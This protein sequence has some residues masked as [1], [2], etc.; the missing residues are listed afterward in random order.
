MRVLVLGAGQDVGKSCVVVRIGGRTLMFDCGMHLGYQD[1][2]RF[3]DFGLLGPP[4]TDL[5]AVVDALLVSHFHLDHVGALPYFTEVLGY[6]GPIFMTYPTAAVAPLMLEDYARVLAERPGRGP[7]FGRQH[8]APALA[9]V[10]P[11]DLQETV[12]VCEGVEVTAYNAGHV[13]GAA[14]LRVT[15]GG[16]SLVYTGDFNTVP[17]RHLAGACLGR[18]APDLLISEATYATSVRDSKAAREA[19]LLSAVHSCVAGGGKVL[20][21]VFAV[22]RAQEL[23]LLLGEFWE[24]TQLDVPIYFSGPLAARASQYYRLLLNWASERVKAGPPGTRAAALAPGRVLPWSAELTHAPGPCVLFAT[25]GMLQGGTSLEVFKAWAPCANNLVLLPSYQARRRCARQRRRRSAA[26]AAAP[27][28]PVAPLT[29]PVVAGAAAAGQVAG[30]L[31]RKLMLGQR[32]G[33]VVDKAPL[34]V[35]CKVYYATVSAHADAKGILQLVAQVAPAAVL[36]VH[37]EPDKMA[38]MSA[39]IAGSLGLPCHTPA[40]GEEVCVSAHAGCV[41]VP[42]AAALLRRLPEGLQ[43]LRA[44]GAGAAAAG[45]LERG[46]A[47]AL[48]AAATELARRGGAGGNGGQP[49]AQQGQEPE[50][51][52]QRQEDQQQQEEQEQPPATAAVRAAQLAPWLELLAAAAHDARQDATAA[53]ASPQQQ[54]QEQEQEQQQELEGTRLAPGGAPATPHELLLGEAELARA[55]AL[56]GRAAALSC[57]LAQQLA[58]ESQRVVLDGVLVVH[59]LPPQLPATQPLVQRMQL[60]PP[61]DA[62]AAAGLRRHVVRLRCRVRLPPA[63]WAAAQGGGAQPPA[64][65]ALTHVAAALRA[66]LPAELAREVTANGSCTAVRSVEFAAPPE[67]RPGV[68]ADGDGERALACS[69]LPHDDA[70]A[71]RCLDLVQSAAGE[72]AAVSE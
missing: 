66:G 27:A 70:L 57:Q 3:P 5:T 24:R 58:L 64:A 28:A 53:A 18:L 67:L 34:D 29:A 10:T 21:P 12:E 20:V 2:R 23:L 45:W 63:C 14:I 68:G 25:P 31:G 65:A 39:R 15:A 32:K 13:L 22:G 19:S 4:G 69:W 54:Q 61:D 50:Q 72:A 6:R 17:D 71:A 36:L 42:T 33:L 43:R 46:D 8:V 51:E 59:H 9:R 62:A 26:A 60:L 37:G 7:L 56:V 55:T 49:R 35:N 16:E 11:I 44:D 41:P 38:F 52:Q 1:E 30:T 40:I 47:A 48:V